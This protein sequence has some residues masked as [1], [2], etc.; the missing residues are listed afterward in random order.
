MPNVNCPTCK[1]AVWIPVESVSPVSPEDVAKVLFES[2]TILTW[3]Q[4]HDI[5]KKIWLDNAAALL[6]KIEM[7]WKR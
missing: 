3:D 4:A 1:G 2:D 6:D 5:D 7:R